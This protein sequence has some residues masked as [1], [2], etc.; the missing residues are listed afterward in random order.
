[1]RKFKVFVEGRNFL[2]DGPDGTD[3]Y[4]FCTTRLIDAD[5]ED[6]AELRAV[7][8]LRANQSLREVVRNE[9]DN[10]PMMYVTEIEELDEVAEAEGQSADAGLTWYVDETT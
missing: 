1:M 2:I 4:A 5:N 10:P 8:A 7:E 3:R 6:D 9:Q